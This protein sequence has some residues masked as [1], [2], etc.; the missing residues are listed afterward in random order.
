[1]NKS[2][3]HRIPI[4]IRINHNSPSILYH[5]QEY[6]IGSEALNNDAKFSCISSLCKL[7]QVPHGEISWLADE[8]VRY[9]W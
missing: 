5:G 2:G 6:W 8:T 1:M 3:S 9:K 4:D 7:A